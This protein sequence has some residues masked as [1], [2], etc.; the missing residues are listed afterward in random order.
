MR[1]KLTDRQTDSEA[2]LVSA[3]A[4]CPPPFLLA[5]ATFGLGSFWFASVIP[6]VVGFFLF[7]FG[8]GL[9]L[10]SSLKNKKLWG[11]LPLTTVCPSIPFFLGGGEGGLVV[12]DQFPINKASPPSG[13]V[14]ESGGGDYSG[15]L[16]AAAS[17]S[18][19]PEPS[20]PPLCLPCVHVLAEAL[21]EE[22]SLQNALVSIWELMAV[23]GGKWSDWWSDD[24]N[25]QTP[26]NT[27]RH[28]G[29]RMSM[30]IGRNESQLWLNLALLT[31]LVF[32]LNCDYCKSPITALFHTFISGHHTLQNIIFRVWSLQVMFI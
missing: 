3:P 26:V 6:W 17:C 15:G 30:L 32:N 21:G 22:P 16:P 14:D 18:Q 9:F 2:S 29:V 5:P 31:W 13:F 25:R 19:L 23:W 1:L 24:E 10:V 12:K 7:V 28:T 27:S 4:P 11:L 8:L 20:P